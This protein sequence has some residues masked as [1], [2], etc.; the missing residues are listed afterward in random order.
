MSSDEKRETPC[1]KALRVGFK[2]S[3]IPEELDALQPR[4]FCFKY[5]DK[6]VSVQKW[7]P[8]RETQPRLY[9]VD[10]SVARSM[11]D[12]YYT[13]MILDNVLYCIETKNMFE[14]GSRHPAILYRVTN[15]I[16]RPTYFRGAGEFLK[17]DESILFNDMSGSYMYKI[18]RSRE[19]EDCYVEIIGIVGRIFARSFGNSMKS[20]RYAHPETL[21]TEDTIPLRKEH[22]D[23]YLANG[24][25]VRLYTDKDACV[26]SL[27]E[28]KMEQIQ[29]IK[30]YDEKVK[31]DPNTKPPVFWPGEE[32]ALRAIM[33]KTDEFEPYTGGRRRKKSLKRRVRNHHTTI[34][35]RRA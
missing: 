6:Y 9:I 13:Y 20:I 8:T 4:L 25:Q 2:V 15:E 10:P 30:Q 26:T 12:G 19:Y 35:R 22:L 29:E 32:E 3:E 27:D 17:K 14:I 28:E 7:R 24:Y 34:R 33:E 18:S 21:F 31:T 11:P 23:E 5:K 1:E 16:R